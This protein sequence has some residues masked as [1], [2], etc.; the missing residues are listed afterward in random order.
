MAGVDGFLEGAIAERENMFGLAGRPKGP[1]YTTKSQEG[2]TAAECFP[3]G[4]P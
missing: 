2:G 3:L 1:I 4:V